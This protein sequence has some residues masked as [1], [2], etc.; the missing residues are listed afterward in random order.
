MGVDDPK[1]V[2][3]SGDVSEK[4]QTDVDQ[5]VDGAA[6]LEEDAERRQE[7]GQKIVAD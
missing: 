2:R 4:R 7:E 6:P 3:D 5:K 1:G